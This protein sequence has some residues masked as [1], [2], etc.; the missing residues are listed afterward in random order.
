MSARKINLQSMLLVAP[1]I[2]FMSVIDKSAW[3][4]IATLSIPMIL[5][6]YLPSKIWN[7]S[8]TSSTLTTDLASKKI[9]VKKTPVKFVQLLIVGLT[10]FTLNTFPKKLEVKKCNYELA[11]SLNQDQAN[12]LKVAGQTSIIFMLNRM[13]T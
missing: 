5:A 9:P 10:I 7:L 2:A 1:V 8:S 4:L 13:G 3:P 11:D 6:R 12:P